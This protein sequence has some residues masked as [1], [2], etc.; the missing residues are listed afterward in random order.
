MAINIPE[1]ISEEH[2]RLAIEN[3][4]HTVSNITPGTGPE[5]VTPRSSVD[6]TQRAGRGLRPRVKG[7]Q[8]TEERISRP[9]SALPEKLARGDAERRLAEAAR[10]EEKEKLRQ[11]HDPK[12]SARIS[13]LERK[14]KSLDKA[15]KKLRHSL[16]SAEKHEAGSTADR[17]KTRLMATSVLV[18]P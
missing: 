6:I 7:N 16:M 14:V 18:C 5:S 8:V 4:G 2:I 1:G 15:L 12:L 11:E 9:S 17:T 13:Y 10:A 3:P